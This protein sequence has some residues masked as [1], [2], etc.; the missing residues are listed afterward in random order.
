[1]LHAFKKTTQATPQ[2]D[3]DL[4]AARLRAELGERR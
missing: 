4:A 1:V 3:L 2:K